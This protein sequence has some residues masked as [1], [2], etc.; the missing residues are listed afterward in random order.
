MFK[1]SINTIMIG[2]ISLIVFVAIAGLVVY[3]TNSSRNMVVEL[4]E[5]S[6]KEMA[7]SIVKICTDFFEDSLLETQT[8]AAQKEMVIALQG[9]NKEDA[10]KILSDAVNFS[11]GKIAVALLFDMQGEIVTGT[12]VNGDVLTKKHS[13][14]RKYSAGIID[15]KDI[16]VSPYLLKSKKLNKLLGSFGAAV[17][18]V[19]GQVIGGVALLPNFDVLFDRYV[20]SLHFGKHGYAFVLDDKGRILAHP[21]KTKILKDMSG[22]DFVSYALRHKN[23]CLDYTFNGVHKF[24]LFREVPSTHWI[25]GMNAN[26]AE[27]AAG[28]NFQRNILVG[29]GLLVIVAIILALSLFSRQLIFDPLSRIIAFVSRVTEGDYKAV[30]EGRFQY[31]MVDLAENIQSMVMEMKN[32]IGF[33]EGI[34]RA[35]AL[36]YVVADEEDKIITVNE[37]FVTLL[38]HTGTPQDAVGQ[39]LGEYVYNDSTRLSI[40]NKAVK[41]RKAIVALE[42]KLPTQQGTEVDIL[43]DASPIYDLDGNLLAGFGMFADLTEIK[44]QQRQIEEQ[45]KKIAATAEEAF[46]VADQMAGASEELSTQIEQASR[47]AGV[48]RERVQETATSMEEMNATVLEVAKN[49]S[50]AAEGSNMAKTNAQEGRKIVESVVKA[51]TEVQEQAQILKRTMEALGKQAED[52]GNVMNVIS[53]IADQTNL[54]ALNAAIEAARAGDAGRG[55][56]V[57]A[58]EVRK[59]AEKT[60][61]AT[62]EV[63]SA[64]SSIQ[65][66][67]RGAAADMDKAVTSVEEATELA[68]QS[69]KALAEIVGLVDRASD[70]V[71][72]IATASEE[73]SATSEE[74]NRAVDEINKVSTETAEAMEQSARAVTELAELAQS[75]NTLIHDLQ[76]S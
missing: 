3:V 11:K 4:Q 1:K 38:G 29:V 15:G 45:N 25:V 72:S 50:G 64:I 35:I 70:Q 31:E 5:S 34:L 14:D 75:L 66:G 30:L 27:L 6:M 57:V 24:L 40:T 58:D 36:P 68:G 22:F 41:E 59:L 49:A 20:L 43:A 55:F 28:A 67:T 8:L 37:R 16:F 61:G 44:N 56:A 71:R 2:V 39:A 62:Q 47:G 23:G 63:G 26:H 65:Q 18:D 74:I 51:I 76:N 33:S 17:K 42:G 60:M 13:G 54:L 48:Q 21:D 73:Q 10:R 69:G 19:S 7:G 32:K 12:N 9:G 46:A 52:I 53:D